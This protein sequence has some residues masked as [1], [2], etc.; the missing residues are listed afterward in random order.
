MWCFFFPHC[1]QVTADIEDENDETPVCTSA[2][3]EAVIFDNVVAGTNVSGF[4]L[5]YHDRDS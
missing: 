3:Y 1:W 4:K 2:L 5:N